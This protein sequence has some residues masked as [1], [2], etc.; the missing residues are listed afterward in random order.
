MRVLPRY[1]K[2][3][4]R[5]RP[6]FWSGPILVSDRLLVVGSHGEALSI[7]PYTGRVLGRIALPGG[8]KISPV[9]AGDTVYVLT[10]DGDLVALR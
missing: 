10:N 3:K 8:V 5:D 7:S 9:A 2:P 1:E 6:I 4:K